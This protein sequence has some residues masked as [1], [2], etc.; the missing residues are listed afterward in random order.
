MRH[1]GFERAHILKPWELIRLHRLLAND[2]I[3]NFHCPACGGPPWQYLLWTNDED[4]H[5]ALVAVC[6]PCDNVYAVP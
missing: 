2:P 3:E 4:Y 6:R 1:G 5:I